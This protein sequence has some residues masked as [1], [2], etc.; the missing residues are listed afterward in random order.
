[1]MRTLLAERFKL[2]ARRE[3]KE[4]SYFALV[5]AKNGPKMQPVKEMPDDFRGTTYGGRINSILQMPVLAYLL[6]RFE[7]ERPIIDGSGLGGM[8]QVKLEWAMRQIQNADPDPSRPS[9]FTALEEQ[10]GLK[11]EAR[12]GPVEILVVESAEKAPTEN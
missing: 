12:K 7:R 3:Q 8:Y 2:M 10:L 1:M 6:S 9:L 4:M 11:L 5:I